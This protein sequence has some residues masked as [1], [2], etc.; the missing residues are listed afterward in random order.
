ME[1]SVTRNITDLSHS[2]DHIISVVNTV[3]VYLSG[4]KAAKENKFDI[5]EQKGLTCSG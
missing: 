2:L 1:K 4:V 3:L 5:K